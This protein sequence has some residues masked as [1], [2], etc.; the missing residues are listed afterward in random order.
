[1]RRVRI[2]NRSRSRRAIDVTS[3]AEVV[4]ASSAADA[5]HPAFSNLF[6]QTEIID[7]RQAILCTRRP[8]SLDEKVPWM[9]H[10]MTMHGA[11]I[12]EISYETDRM[13][14]I[15]RGNTVIAPQAMKNSAALS[16]NQGSVLDPIVA[17]RYNIILDPEES[18]K[19]DMV[20]GIAETRDAAL[21]LIDKY[22]DRRL[23]NRVFELAWTYSQV[24]LRQINAT[25]ATHNYTDALP[26]PSY[27]LILPCVQTKTSSSR[28]VADNQVCGVTPFPVICPS[29]CCRLKIRLTSTW[30]DNLC[31]PTLTGV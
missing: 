14:F 15:G 23:T 20:S 17:I 22:Q 21:G 30:C 7:Q 13:Q 8:R 24:I 4:L 11:E 26:A 6:V 16:G 9:F 27:M 5:I 1:M 2:T 10:L 31:R 12:G 3:Y 19:I 28:T 29:F 25:E 18:V